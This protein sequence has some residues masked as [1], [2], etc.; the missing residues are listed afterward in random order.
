MRWLEVPRV[1]IFNQLAVW[2]G[3]SARLFAVSASEWNFVTHFFL[4]LILSPFSFWPLSK[5][6]IELVKGFWALRALLHAV[7]R[8]PEC[9]FRKVSDVLLHN[10]RSVASSWWRF[11]QFAL[12]FIASGL[13]NSIDRLHNA[14]LACGVAVWHRSSIFMFD[15]LRR[16]SSCSVRLIFSISNGGAVDLALERSANAHNSPSECP[17]SPLLL[18]PPRNCG[19]RGDGALI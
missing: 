16:P 15:L 12:L 14:G 3:T 1:P 5:C 10:V 6:P 9:P 2:R 11:H 4:A 7:R 8:H 19:L 18:G 17:I 13:L